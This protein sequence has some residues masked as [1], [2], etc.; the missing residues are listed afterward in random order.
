MARCGASEEISAPALARGAS[1]V[2]A[3]AAAGS[4][5]TIAVFPRGQRAAVPGG[6]VVR[7]LDLDGPRSHGAVLGF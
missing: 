3:E 5:L 6:C 4:G 7:V 2:L 1:E